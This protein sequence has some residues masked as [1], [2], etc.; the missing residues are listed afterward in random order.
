[1]NKI[2]DLYACDLL[3]DYTFSRQET[4]FEDPSQMGELKINIQ[5]I[6]SMRYKRNVAKTQL[7]LVVA[8]GGVIG[9]FFG[10]SLLSLVEIVY[11]WCIRRFEMKSR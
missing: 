2:N 9:L 5:N 6:P 7:D 11:I 4:A 8:V 1:M 3:I 10:A